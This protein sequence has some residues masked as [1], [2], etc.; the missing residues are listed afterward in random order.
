[1]IRNTF[2]FFPR[3]A[4]AAGCVAFILVAAL[5]L[6]WLTKGSAGEEA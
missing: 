1:M 2:M 4:I 3:V 6:W 5:P